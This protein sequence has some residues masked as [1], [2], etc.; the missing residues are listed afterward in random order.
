MTV[1]GFEPRISVIAHETWENNPRGTPEKSS[2]LLFQLSTATKVHMYIVSP[3]FQFTTIPYLFPLK[4]GGL[5]FNQI[6]IFLTAQVRANFLKFLFVLYQIH[7]SS[8]CYTHFFILLLLFLRFFPIIILTDLKQLILIF[9]L[10]IL[11]SEKNQL[12]LYLAASKEILYLNQLEFVWLISAMR[13][14]SF[15]L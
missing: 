15:D 2:N 14:R 10:S 5:N 9:F 3:V 8:L 13:P 1:T 4:T 12:L 11:D 7:R 6:K